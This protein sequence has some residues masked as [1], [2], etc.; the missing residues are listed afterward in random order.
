[1]GPGRKKFAQETTP[2]GG[3]QGEIIILL[4]YASV[5]PVRERLSYLREEGSSGP[6]RESILG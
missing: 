6:Q 5:I 1:M 3:R 4:G 2:E